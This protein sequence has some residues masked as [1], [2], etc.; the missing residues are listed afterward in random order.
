MHHV[1]VAAGGQVLGDAAS[2]TV[3]MFPA[4]PAARTERTEFDRGV[5]FGAAFNPALARQQQDVVV[6]KDFHGSKG[7]AIDGALVQCTASAAT[8][9]T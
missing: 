8:R 2:T 1:E 6:V 3:F 4:P 7:V 5:A 9:L